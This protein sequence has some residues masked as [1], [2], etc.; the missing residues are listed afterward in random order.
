MLAKITNMQRIAQEFRHLDREMQ[1]QT[2]MAFLFIAEKEFMGQECTVQDVGH[3]LDLTSASATRNVQA[4]GAW[5]RHDK[6][7]HGLVETFE[8][9]RRRTQKFIKLTDK[10]KNL[11]KRIEGY[12]DASQ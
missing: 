5:H 9:P 12:I 6:P 10:G 3:F 11:L 2:I 7:G 1:I 4:L 8:N